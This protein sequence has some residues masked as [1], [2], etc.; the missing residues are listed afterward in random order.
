MPKPAM[1]N[2][3]EH[4]DREERYQRGHLSFGKMSNI[5]ARA[6]RSEDAVGEHQTVAA[7]GQWARQETILGNVIGQ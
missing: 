6:V 7:L 3:G 5:E 1:A 2:A 4:T